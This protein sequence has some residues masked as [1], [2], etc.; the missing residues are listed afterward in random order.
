LNYRYA[1]RGDN[2]LITEFVSPTVQGKALQVLLKTLSPEFLALP[3]PLLKIIPPRPIG[4]T[5]HREVIRVR[6]DLTFDALG[7]A[8]SVADMTASL[9]LNPARAGRLVEYSGRDQSQPSLQYVLDQLINSTIKSPSKPGYLGSI[10]ITVND[11]VL[12][13]LINLANASD[14]SL[15]VR[16]IAAFKIEQVSQY[17]NES[18]KTTA[19]ESWRAHRSG[20][21]D[22]IKQFQKNPQEFKPFAPLAPPPGQ[23]IGTPGSEYGCEY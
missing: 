13:N 11:V 22:R 16:N 21:L 6:T 10:Q 12:N 20:M 9:L 7:A 3:E 19:D 17:I 14:A 18:L 2:Q 5:R 15:H 4:Y 8:E 23:P 1:L